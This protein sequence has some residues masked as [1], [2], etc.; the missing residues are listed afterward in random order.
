MVYAYQ[1]NTCNLAKIYT[2]TYTYTN[3]NYTCKHVYNHVVEPQT[4]KQTQKNNT[5]TPTNTNT[6][7]RSHLVW[8]TTTQNTKK[9]QHRHDHMCVCVKGFMCTHMVQEWA[10]GYHGTERSKKRATWCLE[11]DRGGFYRAR[12][13]KT[14]CKKKM[15]QH[16]QA[17]KDKKNIAKT[18]AK[19]I[20]QRMNV[21]LNLGR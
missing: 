15:Q 11:E 2:Y 9:H 10:Q 20:Y 7:K 19:N 21:S 5:D 13:A 4:P 17:P 18:T 16:K 12:M 1:R 6:T 8:P 14:G 3:T